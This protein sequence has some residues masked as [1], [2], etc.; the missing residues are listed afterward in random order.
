MSQLLTPFKLRE[1]T[2]ATAWIR[3]MCF[4]ASGLTVAAGGL[5]GEFKCTSTCA[6]VVGESG[7][8]S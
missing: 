5:V 2:L 3:I 8:I 1:I 4:V 6:D 7:A